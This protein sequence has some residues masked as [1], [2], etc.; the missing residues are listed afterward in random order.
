MQ[1][2]SDSPGGKDWGLLI[3]MAV[4]IIAVLVMVFFSFKWGRPGGKLNPALDQNGAQTTETDA[5]NGLSIMPPP[6][7]STIE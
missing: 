6:V 1:D 4:V 7:V 2:M 3:L 5:D